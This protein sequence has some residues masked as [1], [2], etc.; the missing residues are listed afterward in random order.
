MVVGTTYEEIR[1]YDPQRRSNLIYFPVPGAGN[2]FI[3]L[4]SVR[5]LSDIQNMNRSVTRSFKA[6]FLEDVWDITDNL[7]LTAGVRW[8]DYSDFGSEVS[9]APG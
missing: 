1:Q 6:F 2:L 3:P 7:R 9:P 8:D 5:G 4:G